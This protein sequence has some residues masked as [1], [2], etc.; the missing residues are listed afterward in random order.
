MIQTTRPEEAAPGLSSASSTKA[1]SQTSFRGW[2][3]L[4][5]SFVFALLQSLC[6]AFVALSG[7]RL[8]IGFSSLASAIGAHVPWSLH[9]DRIRIPMILLALVG[10]LIN[11]YAIRR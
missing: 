3:V 9:T 4:W 11:L 10:S 5:S 6:T 7:L 2:L 1:S 8:V